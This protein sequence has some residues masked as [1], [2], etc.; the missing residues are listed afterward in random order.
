VN[1]AEQATSL[2]AT[3]KIAA[4]V[5]L[6]KAEFPDVR[7][8]LK[9]WLNDPHSRELVDPD[10]IDIGFHLPGWSRRFRCRSFLVQI[11]FYTDATQALRRAIGVEIAGFDHQGKQWQLSTIGEWHCTGATEP[12]SDITA[13]LKTVCRSTLELFNRPEASP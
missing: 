11:R 2:E 1:A 10:S 8:D 12:S 4:V 3:S 13:K 9:P 7:V 6:F 5:N